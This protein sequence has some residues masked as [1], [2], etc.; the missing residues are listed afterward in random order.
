MDTKDAICLKGLTFDTL[1][2]LVPLLLE[3]VAVNCV[4][5]HSTTLKE[6]THHFFL[7]L[8]NN[9]T[10]KHLLLTHDT[11]DDEGV[12]P[13]A[14]SLKTNVTLIYLSI[15]F[16]CITSASCQSLAD[17]LCKSKTLRVL[18]LSHTN[19]DKDGA[20]LLV[21]S[22]ESNDTLERLVL[23]E[24]HRVSFSDVSDRL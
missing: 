24:Q 16:N 7:M 17:L 20:R 21:R 11:I 2:S 15:D 23:D 19:I 10:L 4:N 14:H 13:L 5:I 8:T 12:R 22:L 9:F 3:T 18:S 6:F 1:E